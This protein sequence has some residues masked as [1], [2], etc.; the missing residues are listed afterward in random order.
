MAAETISERYGE[1]LFVSHPLIGSPETVAL[2]GCGKRTPLSM[3]LLARALITRTL[4]PLS[5]NPVAEPMFLKAA[6]LWTLGS[7]S[8]GD[9]K[10]KSGCSVQTKEP[11]LH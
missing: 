3:F 9:L 10:L 2:L 8:W 7:M 11:K 4:W 6:E 5:Y 1:S